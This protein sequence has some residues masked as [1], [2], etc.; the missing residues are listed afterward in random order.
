MRVISEGL[1]RFRKMCPLSR[2]GA[3]ERRQ[4]FLTDFSARLIRGNKRQGMRNLTLWKKNH[5]GV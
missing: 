1:R 4:S 5:A 2:K 3:P